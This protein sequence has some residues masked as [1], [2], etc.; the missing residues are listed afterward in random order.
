MLNLRLLNKVSEVE[1]RTGQSLPSILSK[2]PF[3]NVVTA[4]KVIPVNDLVKMV[5]SV[6]L[7][8][9]V[10]GLCIITPREIESVSPDKLL[11]VL[12]KGNME[13]VR[14]LQEKYSEGHIIKA[15]SK[16]SNEELTELLI[17][18]NFRVICAVINDICGI[19]ED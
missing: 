15:L 11:I 19:I 18:D 16:L 12:V 2:V 17:E 8:K 7:D 14:L 9:L 1:K 6:S 3:G 4:F 13:T 10:E 5:S